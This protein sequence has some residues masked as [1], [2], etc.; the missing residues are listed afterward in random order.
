[1]RHFLILF[2]LPL[3]FA[4]SACGGK[5]N[6]EPPAPLTQFKALLEVV[7]HWSAEAG[8]GDK[9]G[10][11]FLRPAVNERFLFTAAPRG[12][13]RAFDLENGAPAWRADA[14]FTISGGPG[15]GENLVLVGGHGGEV[16]AL[17]ANTGARRW[18]SKV[19]SEVLAPPQVAGGIVSVRSADGKLS[20]LRAKDGQR[21]W[22]Y[23]QPVPVLSLRGTSP[24][25]PRG[26]MILSGFDNGRVAALEALTGKALWESTVAEARGRSELERM[27][28]I[29]A[30]LWL[31]DYA[32]YAATYQGYVAAL[33]ISTG[34]ILWKKEASVYQGLA[35]DRYALYFSD[36][37]GHVWALDRRNGSPLWKQDKLQ[38]RRL[39]A[40]ALI[41]EYLVMGDVEGYVHWLR[42]ED[43][44]FAARAR[45]GKRPI[46]APPVVAGDR[47]LVQDSTGEVTVFSIDFQEKL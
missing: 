42:R 35:A 4:L 10:Y 24:P 47:V 40:P 14:G 12:R 8:G 2:W 19:S 25:A 43:G 6:L 28:D 22:S 36:A 45:A 46:S 17:D 21:L 11:L 13:M 29:D 18:Q 23:V 30:P 41:G 27:V 7:P 15:V 1:M 44:Q 5:D 38:A 34:E 26:D 9:E 39:T 3:A 37:R 20:A 32:I 31:S 33:G 16:L